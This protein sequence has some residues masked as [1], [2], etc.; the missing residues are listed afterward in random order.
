MNTSPLDRLRV[1]LVSTRNPLNIG[2]AARA[3]S[4]FGV[5]HLRVVDP[6]EP[7]FREA[8]S[9][10]GA[11]DLLARAQQ[12]ASVAEAV[13]DCKLVVGTTAVG[14]RQLRH[15]IRTLEEGARAI[16]RQLKTAPVALLFGSERVGLSNDDLSHC[17]WLIRIPTRAEHRSMNLGQAVAICLYELARTVKIAPHKITDSKIPESKIADSRIT[18]PNITQPGFA[19]ANA[20]PATARDLERLTQVFFEILRASGY[21]TRGAAP[22]EQKLRRMLL[23]MNLSATDGELFI[24]MLRQVSWK[25]GLPA[26]GTGKA[27]TPG[28]ATDKPAAKAIGSTAAKPTA[29]A[30]GKSPAKSTRKAR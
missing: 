19:D 20:I 3:M 7:S 8:R 13:A 16:H 22:T 27:E 1:V 9:A 5:D 30:A 12:P 24:G 10:V 17:H 21:V 18:Q 23:R 29:K 14:E 2:A 26:L 28:K 15:Q 6:Y 11:A 25:L 4:N